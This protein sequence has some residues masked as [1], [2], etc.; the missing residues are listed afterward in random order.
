MLD[1]ATL[2]ATRSSLHRVGAHV[3]ARRRFAESGRLGL[4]AGPGGI[5][6][7]A[8]GEGPEVLRVSGTVLVRERASDADRRPVAGASLRQ[9]A[10]FAG[11]DVDAPF[12]AGAAT[13]AL[14]DPDAP[15]ELDPVA[16]AE[17]T[18]W[19]A[20]A[21]PVLDA[22]SAALPAGSR[23]STIQLWPEHFDAGAT[24]TGAEGTSVNLGFSAGD[25]AVDEPYVYV[26][27][28]DARRP[29]APGF[30]NAEFGAARTRAEAFATADPEAFCRRF[31][32]EGLE[33][34]GVARGR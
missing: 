17:V 3:L 6:T 19:L 21:W 14:G 11:A 20:R 30:W 16:A 22:L 4:R 10:E 1:R 2:D 5:V 9:L 23:T 15:L 29:G 31:L 18:D 27:P 33:R 13:P 24:V 8:F 32:A 12:S 7:P 34:L 28:W 26:G 25:A